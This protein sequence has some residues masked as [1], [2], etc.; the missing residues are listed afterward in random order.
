MNLSVVTP[1]ELKLNPAPDARFTSNLEPLTWQKKPSGLPRDSLYPD[2]FSLDI[3]VEGR[4]YLKPGKKELLLQ[5]SPGKRNALLRVYPIGYTHSIPLMEHSFTLTASHQ[6]QPFSNPDSGLAGFKLNLN[7]ATGLFY[8]SFH[9]GASGDDRQTG[10][11]A[12]A[13]LTF[14]GTSYA[15]GHLLWT[16]MASPAHP[17]SAHS[18]LLTLESQQPLEM[19]SPGSGIAP[20]FSPGSGV[21]G[22]SG[23]IG[24]PN[25]GT[26]AS[27]N[28]WSGQ[29]S[30]D[31]A[32]LTGGVPGSANTGSNGY[33]PLSPI[34]LTGTT[35]GSSVT[36]TS[37][38][39]WTGG[40]GQSAIH[41]VIQQPSGSLGVN[42][43]AFITPRNP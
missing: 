21:G 25:S 34:P 1:E 8:G 13:I 9:N 6:F 5:S 37:G 42:N 40:S 23:S 12:G 29:P 4:R 15:S 20:I 35:S 43:S 39:S 17:Q 24:P 22:I 30:N 16:T 33:T 19:N 36:T 7:A 38:S 2:G 27:A 41:G 26:A 3:E 28:A 10:K 18:Y 14:P 11:F 32:P 31:P